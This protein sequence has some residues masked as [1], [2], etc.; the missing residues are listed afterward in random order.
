MVPFFLRLVSSVRGN[1]RD[2]LKYIQSPDR[3]QEW[4]RYDSNK[5]LEN[6]EGTISDSI[7]M[8]YHV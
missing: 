3:I 8:N 6:V 7:H 1:L 2:V 5:V 4:N